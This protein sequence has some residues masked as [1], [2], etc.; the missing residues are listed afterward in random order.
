MHVSLVVGNLP[1]NYPGTVRLLPSQYKYIFFIPTASS[2]PAHLQMCCD[3][4]K[5]RPYAAH[6]TCIIQSCCHARSQ[7]PPACHIRSMG[8]D[9]ASHQL[10]STPT[11]KHTTACSCCAARRKNSP[12]GT[13]CCYPAA[14][15]ASAAACLPLHAHVS[16][17][18]G[19]CRSRLHKAS[20]AAA[21]HL[22]TL[23]LTALYPSSLL[24]SALVRSALI[25]CALVGLK[26]MT[27]LLAPPRSTTP[28]HKGRPGPAWLEAGAAA[29]PTHSHLYPLQ[30]CHT[31]PL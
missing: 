21:M 27:V 9:A 10:P 8:N 13:A 17:Q 5:S 25:R 16:L 3:L 24:P 6:S 20:P 31:A 15:V 22:H 28:C 30:P 19:Q 18:A 7:L 11:A 26:Q 1:S 2:T 4:S 29:Q 12:P 23:L 14:P